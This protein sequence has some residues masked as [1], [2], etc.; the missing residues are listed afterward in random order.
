MSLR[1]R[2]GTP[3]HTPGKTVVFGDYSPVRNLGFTFD[4]SNILDNSEKFIDDSTILH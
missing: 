2:T 4:K 1:P 3:R